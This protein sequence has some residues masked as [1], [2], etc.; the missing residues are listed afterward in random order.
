MIVY[1]FLTNGNNLLA[2]TSYLKDAY[3][4]NM[5]RFVQFTLQNA[6]FIE[7][8]VEKFAYFDKKQ[9]FCLKFIVDNTENTIFL[10]FIFFIN[11]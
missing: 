1:Y 9:Y 6:L 4:C 11:N 3:L 10:Q 8:F 5:S 7:L 2:R